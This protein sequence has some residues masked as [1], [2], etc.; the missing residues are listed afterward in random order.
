MRVKNI[1]QE[2]LCF[3]LLN[4][5]RVQILFF[6]LNGMYVISFRNKANVSFLLW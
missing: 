4:N 5:A 6:V 1:Q 3:K 2:I